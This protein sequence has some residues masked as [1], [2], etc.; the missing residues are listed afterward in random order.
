[1]PMTRLHVPTKNIIL[2]GGLIA[3]ILGARCVSST[4]LISD[5]PKTEASPPLIPSD[6]LPVARYGRYTLVELTSQVS[7]HNLLLQVVNV[8]MQATPHAT[9][10]DGLRQVLQRSGSP[11]C[12]DHPQGAALYK[13]PLP[14]AHLYLGPMCLHDA[15]LTLAG[16][17]PGAASKC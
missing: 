7:Q 17:H 15:L 3:T 10:G 14:A 1:M 2:I 4:P 5:E 8:S 9:V 12:D 13:L 6:W 16:P 11:L